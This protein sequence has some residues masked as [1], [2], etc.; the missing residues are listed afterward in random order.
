MHWKWFVTVME[1]LCE[2]L[3]IKWHYIHKH[4]SVE[5]YCFERAI[6]YLLISSFYI[7][8]TLHYILCSLLTVLHCKIYFCSVVCA[9]MVKCL[10]TEKGKSKLRIKD[11]AMV[12][13]CDAMELDDNG[14]EC[15]LKII[16]KW[17]ESERN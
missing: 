11:T 17:N 4:I 1:F 15:K 16:F 12:F 9:C 5:N 6:Y 7:Q 8:Q 3:F 13:T 14:M 10:P 2:Y